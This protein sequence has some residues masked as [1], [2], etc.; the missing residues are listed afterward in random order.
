M[1]S[2][3]PG[4]GSLE[5]AARGEQGNLNS[6]RQ[7]FDGKYDWGDQFRG[8][9][10]GYT[11]EEVRAKAAELERARINRSLS[12]ERTA[13]GMALEG[14]GL[15]GSGTKIGEGQTVEDFTSQLLRD[16]TTGKLA[17]DYLSL[18][19]AEIGDL[20]PNA[21]AATIR[22]KASQLRTSNKKAAEAKVEAKEKA[23]EK[24]SD[25]RYYTNL[26][27]QRLDRAEQRLATKEAAMLGHKTKLIELE[28]LKQRDA[29]EMQKYQ[30]ELAHRKEQAREKRTSNLVQALAGLG[31]AF[32][33]Q[34]TEYP[35]LLRI[36]TVL[37]K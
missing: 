21:S 9:L 28:I 14:T 11:Q 18:E 32:A 34:L 22:N 30:Y 1:F 16:T 29:Y 27:E 17:Q 25:D 36:F 31:A 26:R 7:G 19:N 8:L 4:V 33:I 15:K 23:A 13:A 37:L 24:R 10:G 12:T 2:W 5:D 20:G 6:T 3:L 35:I